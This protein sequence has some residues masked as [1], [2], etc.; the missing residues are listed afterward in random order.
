[1]WL[2]IKKDINMW[3]SFMAAVHISYRILCHV[4]TESSYQQWR[5]TGLVR[6]ISGL[7][8][9]DQNSLCAHWQIR[10]WKIMCWNIAAN[11]IIVR[12]SILFWSRAMHFKSCARPKTSK[13]TV[14]SM[15]LCVCTCKKIPA[16]LDL[17]SINRLKKYKHRLFPMDHWWYSAF[18]QI[19][20]SIV[21]GRTIRFKR[22]GPPYIIICESFCL[23]NN[24]EENYQVG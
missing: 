18:H 3:F 4:L 16:S 17:K 11:C 12:K 22:N 13:S 19:S 20:R 24:S 2:M 23:S 10:V 7:P 6:P 14:F 15:Y 8:S 21:S 1:M 9:S 5:Q